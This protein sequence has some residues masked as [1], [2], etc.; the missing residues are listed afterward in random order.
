MV[1]ERDPGMANISTTTDNLK[2]E[3]EGGKKNFILLK[4]PLQVWLATPR[5]DLELIDEKKAKDLMKK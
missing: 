1:W 3:V 2:I 5:F 4:M